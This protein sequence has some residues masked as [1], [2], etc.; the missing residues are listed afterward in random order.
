[1]FTSM[2]T[3]AA[4]SV[5]GTARHLAYW[6]STLAVIAIAAL[7]VLEAFGVYYFPHHSWSEGI[8]PKV[9]LSRQTVL[10]H[11][12]ISVIASDVRTELPDGVQPTFLGVA[13]PVHATDAR[14][15]LFLRVMT[16]PEDLFFLGLIWIVRK[17]VLSVWAGQSGEVSL[18]IRANVWRLRWLA[19]LLAALWVYHLFL[20]TLTEEVSFFTALNG[21]GPV[22]AE[23]RPWYLTNG[24][25]AV[26]LLLLILAQVFSHGARLQKDVEGLV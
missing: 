1:M 26:A 13:A 24:T 5:G 10:Y 14:G 21:F 23:V 15:K 16:L 2:T 25:L 18:F 19:G 3:T 22:I 6:L 20:P 11:E 8:S 17:I 7:T 9:I 12:Y 4:A